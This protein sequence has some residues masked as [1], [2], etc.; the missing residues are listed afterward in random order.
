MLI[1]C[2]TRGCLKQTEAKL[3]KSTNEVICDECGNPIENITKFAKKTLETI[4]QINRSV[5]KQAFQAACPSCHKNQPLYVQDNK[6]FCGECNS[7]VQVSAAFLNGL[8]MYLDSQAANAAVEKAN[9]IL[10]GKNV[11]GPKKAVK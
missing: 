11:K 1:T 6:A 9:D 5:K 7:Q 4:G 8:K 10:S 3:N 2:T